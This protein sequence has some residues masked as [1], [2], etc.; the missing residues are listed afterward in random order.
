[1]FSK[2][3]SRTFVPRNVNRA[4]LY[5]KY[6]S[7][8]L[9]LWVLLLSTAPCFLKDECLFQCTD[10]E[11]GEM[12]H[13]DGCSCT[14]CC[15]SPFLHCNT[16]TGCPIPQLFHSPLVAIIQL[17]DNPLSFYKERPIPQF[18]SSIWQPPKIMNA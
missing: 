17:N 9:A 5:M 4:V 15:C 7:Y 1:M 3:K 13:D 2:Q 8:I 10:N 14:D 11:P 6:L 16:C 12:C 18:S